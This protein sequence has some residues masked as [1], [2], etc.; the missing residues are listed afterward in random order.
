MHALCSR[1]VLCWDSV[2]AVEVICLVRRMCPFARKRV[3]RVLCSKEGNMHEVLNSSTR[4][5][6]KL[7]NA[8]CVL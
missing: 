7:S 1:C 6:L 8:V 4:P 3:E 2:E 5:M